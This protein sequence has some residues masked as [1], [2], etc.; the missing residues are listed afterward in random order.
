MA[1]VSWVTSQEID[2]IGLSFMERAKFC[3]YLNTVGIKQMRLI[4]STAIFFSDSYFD[5][6]VKLS[7]SFQAVGELSR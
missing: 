4:L 2:Y 5:H 7:S 3:P 6:K 1:L